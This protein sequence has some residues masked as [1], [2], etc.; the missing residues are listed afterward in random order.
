MEL[1]WRTGTYQIQQA[2]NLTPANPWQ[3]SGAPLQD[4]SLTFP[5]GPDTLFWCTRRR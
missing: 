3:D 4:N 1:D 2:T 5:V